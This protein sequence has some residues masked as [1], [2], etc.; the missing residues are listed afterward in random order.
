MPDPN[1]NPSNLTSKSP[2]SIGRV[3]NLCVL[4][5]NARSLLPKFDELRAACLV[6]SPDIICIS[7]TWLDESISNNELSLQNFNIVRR[8][9]NRQGGGIL[10]YVNNFYSHSLVFSGSDDLELIVLSVTSSF[11]KVAV[12]LFYRPP[13][14]SHFIFDTLLTALC[15]H[16]NASL[17]SNF[18]LLGDFNVDF[19]NITHPLLPKLHALSSSLCLSQVEFE[20]TH[21]VSGNATSLIDLIYR[22]A[23]NFLYFRGSKIS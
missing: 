8:D 1:P 9:R 2:A 20:P 17:L 5:Y 22:I 14:S 11:L 18:I 19:L 21:I 6:Y 7:E 12:G 10:I 3:S 23:P 4:Y 15:S 16:I 13:S